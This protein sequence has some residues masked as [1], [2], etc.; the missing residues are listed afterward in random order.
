MKFQVT[1]EDIDNSNYGHNKDC[2]IAKAVKRE[3]PFLNKLRDWGVGGTYIRFG[4]ICLEDSRLP[5]WSPGTETYRPICFQFP[6]YVI[7]EALSTMD[8]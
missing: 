2:A 1:Q 5:N 3:L 8:S 6:D 4:S 7:L